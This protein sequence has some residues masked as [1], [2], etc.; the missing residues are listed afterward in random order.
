MP[1][2]DLH[3]AHAVQI[4]YWLCSHAGRISIAASR[5]QR[6]ARQIL[7]LMSAGVVCSRLEHCSKQACAPCRLAGLSISNHVMCFKQRRAHVDLL[8]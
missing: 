1:V 8:P 4:C 6:P 7:P 5:A 3:Q 2:H